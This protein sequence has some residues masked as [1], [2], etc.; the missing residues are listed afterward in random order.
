MAI[1]KHIYIIDAENNVKILVNMCSFSAGSSYFKV[2]SVM[3]SLRP[4]TE[5]SGH[6][7]NNPLHLL[8]YPGVDTWSITLGTAIAPGH[9]SYEGVV[10]TTL[11]GDQ[12]TT[13]VTLAG[14]LA[15]V[16]G[17]QHVLCYVRGG[18][19]CR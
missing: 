19:H 11:Q 4:A 8:C 12:G 10:P 15:R 17:T 7:L 1:E 14:V 18:V 5:G 13:R 16:R 9:H 6:V 3:I 2:Y